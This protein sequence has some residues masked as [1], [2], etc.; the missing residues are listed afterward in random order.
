M[1]LEGTIEVDESY[2]DP[3]RIPGKRGR[4]AGGK[5]IVFGIFKRR[6]KVYTEIVPEARKKILQCV[7]RGKMYPENVIQSDG[8]RGYD[9]LVDV[10]YDKHYR[11]QHAEDEFAN[12]SSYINGTNRLGAL[13]S[14]G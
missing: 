10:G 11:V 4:G 5:T 9:G 3:K 12:P 14:A 2:F 7:V 8:W 1:P 6:G 13:P